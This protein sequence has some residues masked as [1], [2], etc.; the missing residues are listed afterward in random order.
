MKKTRITRV[1]FLVVALIMVCALALV[2]C[3]TQTE[4][5]KNGHKGGTAT[6]AKKA[7][8]EVCGEEYG[9][10][11]AH[12]GGTATCTQ[13]AVC[14]V[15]GQEYGQL[16]EHIDADGNLICD[17]CGKD[18]RTYYAEDNKNYT[19]HSFLAMSPSNWNEMDYESAN[20]TNILSFLSSGFF[21]TDYP[22]IDEAAGKFNADGTLNADNLNFE[23]YVLKY[24]AA[25]KLTDV[26]DKYAAEWGLTED[27]ITDG[28]YIWQ[29]T[30]RHDLSW[31]DGTPIK[32]E[33]FVYSMKEQLNYDLLPFRASTY[34]SENGMKLH[35]A[36]AYYYNGRTVQL[37]STEGT[38]IGT[39]E[40]TGWDKTKADG[41]LSKEMQ[42]K[43]IFSLEDGYVGQWLPPYLAS[44]GYEAYLAYGNAWCVANIF[45]GTIEQGGYFATDAD[46]LAFIETIEEMEGLTLAE[47]VA[48]ETMSTALQDILYGFWCTAVDEEFGFFT[49]P[50]TYPELS[51]DEVGIFA[52]DDYN[53][54]VVLD[55]PE[56][57]LKEDG[58][59][60]FNVT[61]CSLPL[62]KKDLYESCKQQ[63]ILGADNW[64][65][66][67]CTSVETTAS[68]G[69]YKLTAFQTG[70]QYTLERNPNWYGYYL[71]DNR[72]Q[73]LTDKMVVDIIETA[74]A[75]RM[76]FWAG[77]IDDID[78]AALE[79]QAPA[80]QNSDYA[81]FTPG[82][83]GY[84]YGVQLFSDLKVL[85]QNGQNNS[86]LAIKDFRWALSLSFDR[87]SFNADQ[88]TGMDLG[89]GLLGIDY[90]YDAETG[91]TYRNSDQAKA[92]LLRTYGFTQTDDGKWT[93]GTATYGDID[94]ATEAMTGYNL[95]LAKQKLALA[96]EELTSN[97][98]KYNYDPS[99]DIIFRLGKFNAKAER[100]QQLLQA[101]IDTL[102]AGSALEGKIKVT[103]V[104]TGSDSAEDF[105]T[106]KFEFYCVAAIG[107]AI[108]YPFNSIGSYIGLGSVNYHEYVD[109]SK[110]FLKMTMPAGD[111][112]GAGQELNLSVEDWF[113]SLNGNTDADVCSYNWM[114]GKCPVEVRLEILAMLEEYA[115]GQY[116]SIQVAYDSSAY[117]HS[118]KYHNIT[119][120][121]NMF[122]GLGGGRYIRYDYTDEDWA[123]FVASYNND[124]SVFYR[125]SGN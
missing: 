64:T 6:C 47:I 14:E 26:T 46:L 54:V 53:I 122:M 107:G 25:T 90:C 29:I 24:D 11:A 72:D 59:L 71:A 95:A 41:G 96:I 48:D 58:S 28:G 31:D 12:K 67:Y 115:L 110:D 102:I 99:K 91:A 89:L 124:L 106:D 65:T 56:A 10:L 109:C 32:A 87:V 97:P 120:N 108:L 101:N 114:E 118:A 66:T 8:C 77:Q 111:Y 70:K 105:R 86:I 16:A 57:W 113:N 7:V 84:A 116:R 9:E 38:G 18:S 43:M 78:F 68:W 27:Q 37:D 2:A 39:G 21:T 49:R 17:I 93:D 19:S 92:A 61:N 125:T 121:Y 76:A 51:F 75:Q 103:I 79:A 20:D 1:L 123:E 52:A 45:M 60:S 69:A 55:Q 13:K 82:G 62:V 44:K 34:W 23:K 104:E 36:Q 35:N 5:E 88:M 117:L 22:L 33:D 40:Y 94:E 50:Q 100:R 85:N 83:D 15:C 42:D 4:C 3:Q 98:E 30:L 63:P 119:D 81:V 73:Y 80:Y 74:E 112:E